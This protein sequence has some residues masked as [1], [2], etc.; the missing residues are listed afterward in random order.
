MSDGAVLQS[1]VGA[2]EMATGAAVDR[3]VQALAARV[4]TE[5]PELIVETGDDLIRLRSRGLAARAF[6]SRHRAADPRLAG[7]VTLSSVGGQP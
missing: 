4:A 5:F 7:L 6:G 1:L 2:A 3:A